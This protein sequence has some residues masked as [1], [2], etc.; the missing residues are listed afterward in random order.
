MFR[1]ATNSTES[2]DT[3]RRAVLKKSAI[4]AGIAWTTPVISTLTQPVA[5]ATG[6]GGGFYTYCFDDAG[7][8]EGW[9]MTGLWNVTSDRSLSPSFSLHYGKGVGRNYRTGGG[10]NSG[11]ATSPSFVVPTTGSRLLEFDVWRE[12]ENFA[13]GTWDEFTVSILPTGA[14]LYAV[15][16]DGGTAGAWEHITINLAGYAGSTV[17][18][19]LGFDTKDGN[20][21]NFEGIYV[22]NIVVPG[23]V[24]PGGSGLSASPLSSRSLGSEPGWM[25]NRPAPTKNELRRRERAVRSGTAGPD[26]AVDAEPQAAIKNN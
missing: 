11:S 7:D 3:S 1:M 23:A 10:S 16:R 6:S 4:F 21:N 13:S 2:S 12:V 20:Y 14:V 9:T 24:P 5:A 22:D 19:V 26:V 25:P 15:S 18:L 17:Q 8:P